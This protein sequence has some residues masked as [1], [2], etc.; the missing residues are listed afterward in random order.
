MLAKD[1]LIAAPAPTDTTFF[2]VYSS[3]EGKAGINDV[4][5]YVNRRVEPEQY[6]D[7]NF[8]N[9]PGYLIVQP[10]KTSPV[11][12]VTFDGREIRN[13]DFVSSSPLIRIVLIDENVFRLKK[14]TTQMAILLSSPCG[15]LVCTERIW[16][17]SSA[18]KWFPATTTSHFRV[19]YT[20]SLMD[21]PY[22]LS[23]EAADASGNASGE[24]PYEVSFQVKSDTE[25]TFN[26]V[27][28]N[29]SSVGFFFNFELTG[30][31]L[32]QEFTLEIFSST[33][34]LV[35]RFGIEDVQK[36]YI[37]TNEIIW[38]GVDASGKPL[39]NGIY[40]YRLRVK[41][42]DRDLNET[43]KLVWIR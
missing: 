2:N 29:P 1:S 24:E 17:S 26:G 33:G 39:T 37:G 27:Y 35:S 12:E 21:G 14:D 10:D 15:A 38:N 34:Q 23:V 30:N 25:I 11:L 3:T 20:P 4:N 13:D 9:L 5:V 18:I 6:Y 16:F 19:E 7:N 31:T 40:L 32:P 42:E 41:V 8:A 36:F 22:V 43:G 28:P